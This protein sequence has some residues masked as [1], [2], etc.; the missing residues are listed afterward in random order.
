MGGDIGVESIVGAG[1]VFWFELDFATARELPG[2]PNPPLTLPQGELPAA[3]ALRNLLC[4]EDNRANMQRVEQLIAPRPNIR[5]LSAE[6]GMRGISGLQALKI[7]RDEPVTAH[8]PVL[9]ISA[10]A[11]PRDI[12]KDLAAGLLCYFTKP[13]KVNEFMA[14]LDLALRL[15]NTASDGTQ[16]EEQAWR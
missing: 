12:E 1:S 14:A 15:S 4:V 2:G 9:T 10:N 11:M 3:A 13:I 7:L 6:D 8:I 5:L 16:Q